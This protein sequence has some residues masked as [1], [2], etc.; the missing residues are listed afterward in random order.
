MRRLG[1]CCFLRGAPGSDG[2]PGPSKVKRWEDD[3]KVVQ[4]LQG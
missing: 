1:C 2:G 4:S 3:E